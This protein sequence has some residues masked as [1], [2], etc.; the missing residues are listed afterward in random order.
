M[1]ELDSSPLRRGARLRWVTLA[2]LV[3]VL[4]VS[5]GYLVWRPF[6]TSTDAQPLAF[7]RDE[8]MAAAT[9]FTTT[10]NTY[11]PSMLDSDSKE[12]PGY[13][14]KVGKLLTSQFEASFEQG[15]TLAEATVSAQGAG[16]VGKV[17]AAGVSGMDADSATVMVS[18]GI[19]LSYPKSKKSSKRVNVGTEP[20]RVEVDLVK[21]HGAWLVDDWQPAEKDPSSSNSSGVAQ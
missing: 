7:E 13:R 21:Q 2:V 16:R 4:L 20:F 3:A 17:Y 15:V 10:V 9:K 11:G 19:T 18:G 14:K 12:M 5:V 1:T 8:V 6:G